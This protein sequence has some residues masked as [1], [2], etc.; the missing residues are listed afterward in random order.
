[1][2]NSKMP[3]C[4]FRV[5]AAS[6][7]EENKINLGAFKAKVKIRGPGECWEWTGA[8]DKQGYGRFHVGK[9]RNSAMLSHRI[10][11]GLATGE[12]PE[13][14]CHRCDNPKC[15]NP[16]HLFGGTRADNNADMARKGR[17]A[18]EKPKLR[19]QKHHQAKITDKQAAE[20]RALYSNGGVTQRQIAATYGVCQRTI[21]K[22]VRGISFRAAPRGQ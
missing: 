2:A 8:V 16:A 4:R 14:V 12:A 21:N 1:M 17:A 18:T 10:A 11:Y 22:V 5:N 7:A 20:I 19:G 9:S 3:E 13:A 6:F 15:C